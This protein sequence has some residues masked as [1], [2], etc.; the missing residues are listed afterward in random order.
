VDVLT[1][2]TDYQRI[3]D[4]D[5]LGLYTMASGDAEFHV[6]AGGAVVNRPMPARP[7]GFMAIFFER[8]GTNAT[9]RL[10][11]S[12]ATTAAFATSGSGTSLSVG[13]STVG[14]DRKNMRVKEIILGNNNLSG[15]NFTSLAAYILAEYGLT[16]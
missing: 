7:T 14:G 2:G 6:Y 5:T 11:G 1:T 4:L 13:I 8:D 9:I 12:S 3:V 10:N 15:P 16:L